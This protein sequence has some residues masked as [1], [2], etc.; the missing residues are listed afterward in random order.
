M[1][2]Q[3]L[4]TPFVNRDLFVGLTGIQLQRVYAILDGAVTIE[5]TYVRTL[6]A[7]CNNGGEPTNREW[8]APGAMGSSTR[9][10]KL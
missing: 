7:T 5:P 4:M 3:Y 6:D 10:T 2:Q 1:S 9:G 8:H